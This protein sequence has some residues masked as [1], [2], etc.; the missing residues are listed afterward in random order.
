MSC[1]VRTL[2]CPL[3]AKF[4]KRIAEGNVS[5]FSYTSSSLTDTA[6]LGAALGEVAEPGLVVALEGGLG[7]GKT[8]FV[9]AVAEG[10]KVADPRLVTSPTFILIQEYP[11]RLPIYHF[12]T[13]RLANPAAFADL[14]TDEYFAG[15]GICLVEWAD[16]VTEHLPAAYVKVAIDSPGPTTR[17][18]ECSSIGD[19]WTTLVDRW[20]AGVSVSS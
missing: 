6:R 9:R 5:T 12:D 8:T 20:R 14:G 7:A 1:C 4:A 10:L 11:A 3:V 2:T 13:Y 19:R 15:D 17:H 16:R 18:F